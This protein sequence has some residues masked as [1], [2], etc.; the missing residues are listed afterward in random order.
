ML[1][2][3][4]LMRNIQDVCAL[5]RKKY[6][7]EAASQKDYKDSFVINQAID[8][9]RGL[10]EDLMTESI[11]R[12]DQ[13]ETK[14]SKS[15]NYRSD[16]YEKLTTIATALQISESEVC[17]RIMYYTLEEHNGSEATIEVSVLKEKVVLLK[18][19]MEKSMIA[20]NEVMLAISLLENKEEY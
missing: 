4:S 9:F 11:S 10:P 3:I 7:G 1:K 8:A 15:V 16:C 18:A 2:S 20:L 19:Q 12:K 14:A 5:L 17:R 6:F 13:S